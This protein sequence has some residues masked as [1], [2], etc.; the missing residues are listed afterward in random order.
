MNRD[1]YLD[2][3]EVNG[4]NFDVDV[5]KLVKGSY[6]ASAKIVIKGT[7]VTDG[8]PS[9]FYFYPVA[10]C[11]LN[12][13]VCNEG[14][15]G[16]N[17]PPPTPTPTP[18][19][20]SSPYSCEKTTSCMDSFPGYDC[21]TNFICCA[22]QEPATCYEAP[23]GGTGGE[24]DPCKYDA[25]QLCSICL[26]SLPPI[27]SPEEE[28]PEPEPSLA[29]LCDQVADKNSEFWKD[30]IE[31]HNVD[32]GIWT[33]IGCLPTDFGEIVSNYILKYGIGIAGGIAFLYLLYGIFLI[34]TSAGNAEK[35]AQ[36]KEIIV[37]AISGL[38]LIIFSV[39]LLKVIGV[40]ILKIPGFGG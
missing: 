3:T 33:A 30:C 27:P 24:P 26:P 12:F 14:E 11:E 17:L 25:C 40:D 21:P 31:C 28:P 39:F 2:P 9:N 10:M 6:L 15:V 1:F 32:H 37:S 36:A 19:P 34:M 5:G 8:H 4:L 13:N 23:C 16:C 20:C 22:P 18:P 29:P 38:I 7:D 35:I